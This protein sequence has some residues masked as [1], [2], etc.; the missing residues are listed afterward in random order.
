[1]LRCREAL[2]S[3]APFEAGFGAGQGEQSSGLCGDAGVLIDRQGQSSAVRAWRDDGQ[4]D[5]STVARAFASSAGRGI[6]RWRGAG[7]LWHADTARGRGLSSRALVRQKVGA[8][9]AQLAAH[10]VG[11]RRGGHGRLATF[12]VRGQ[13]CIGTAAVSCLARQTLAWAARRLPVL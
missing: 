13:R 7:N 2:P 8:D 1:V 12:A 10:A 11:G 3:S 9:G 4:T 6:W 5:R